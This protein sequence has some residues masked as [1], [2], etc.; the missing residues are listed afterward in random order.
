[1]DTNYSAGTGLDLSGGAFSLD[2]SY[3][4]P[5]T[6][7]N[8]QIAEW[9]GLA[10][11]C[12]DDDVSGDGGGGDIT[13]VYAGDGLSGGGTSGGVTISADTVYLQR[14]VNGTC[15][16]GNAIRVVHDDGSVTCEPVGDGT[17]PHDHWGETWSGSGIGLTL[18]SSNEDALRLYGGEDG[19]QIVE[20][21]DDGVF[22]QSA[23]QDGVLV[24]SPGRDGVSVTE[25]GSDGFYVRDAGDDGLGV[26][27]AADNGV[28][29]DWAGN[30]GVHVGSADRYGVYAE[31]DDAG[32]Y[33]KSGSQGVY[34]ETDAGQG[35]Y[36]IATY[37]G[38]LCPI[39]PLLPVSGGYFVAKGSCGIGV[40]GS[41]RTG[42]RG[43]A[44]TG[45]GVHGE[46]ATGA[47]AYGVST[48]GGYGIHGE[49]TAG[50]YA[51]Y[52]VAVGS[53]EVEVHYGGYFDGQGN[54]GSG[55]LAKAG[56]FGYAA[57][58]Y[59][60]VMI[61]S[62]GGSPVVELGEGLDYAEGFDVSDEKE[63]G[64]GT[65]LIIDPENPGELAVST[66]PYDTK[67]AGIVAGAQ[68]EGSGVRLGVGQFDHDVALAGRV[69]CNV[70]ATDEGIAPGDLLTTATI[71]GYA[72]K[73]TDHARAQ[74]A[75]LG[76]AM[77][78]L[79]EGERGQILVLVT[80]Q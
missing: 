9:S 60:P 38:N 16:A 21:V 3:R 50:G 51:V 45:K 13:A 42:V 20:A 64:P 53:G 2:S 46:A 39:P 8:G 72:M 31:G 71:P 63:I 58:L 33:G 5:Q 15:D 79:E 24:T 76:K 57:D 28:Q 34:G 44:T 6:C 80:L 27:S 14:R 17:G 55:I 59:G 54:Y 40:Y 75:I 25:P 61:R 22:V 35:V 67:V 68:G 74:G 10:W 52:G 62:R 37:T 41:G 36:G 49:V 56:P 19:L 66:Q 47:G 73:A 48:D 7:G 1:D 23:G 11:V 29:V 26:V 77:D 4:L 12:G 18:N 43:K 65:V 70:D 30:D 69:Y 32:V 78:G